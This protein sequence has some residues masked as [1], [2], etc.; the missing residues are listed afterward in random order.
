MQED[1]ESESICLSNTHPNCTLLHASVFS[2]YF[3]ET[4][5]RTSHVSSQEQIQ[6]L[7]QTP[8]GLSSLRVLCLG[9]GVCRGGWNSRS[10]RMRRERGLRT[11]EDS[12][13][14]KL[15][16]RLWH[17][18]QCALGLWAMYNHGGERWLQVHDTAITLFQS[19]TQP[20][21]RSLF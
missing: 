13:Y 4:V 8:R 6:L 1:E 3:E 2:W 17:L 21:G 11:E 14:Q 5:W 19:E 18:Q 16:D 10:G 9:G 12:E 20:L 15:D 7:A